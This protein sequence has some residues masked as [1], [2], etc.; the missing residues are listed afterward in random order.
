MVPFTRSIIPKLIV[1]S[2]VICPFW[3]LNILQ[4]LVPISGEIKYN[5]WWGYETKWS[6]Y[7]HCKQINGMRSVLS[8]WWHRRFSK[9]GNRTQLNILC[10]LWCISIYHDLR[11]IEVDMWFVM[12]KFITNSPTQMLNGCFFKLFCVNTGHLSSNFC[13]VCTDMFITTDTPVAICSRDYIDDVWLDL[14]LR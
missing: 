2:L 14:M 4:H 12:C 8:H 10:G 3:K 9:P 1:L 7:Q 6:I 13:S 11:W 5:I